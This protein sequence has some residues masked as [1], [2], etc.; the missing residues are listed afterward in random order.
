MPG[1]F[2]TLMERQTGLTAPSEGPADMRNWFM[3]MIAPKDMIGLLPYQ[4]RGDIELPAE[5][6]MDPKLMGPDVGGQLL[7]AFQNANKY[8]AGQGSALQRLQEA[9]KK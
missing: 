2:E 4:G 5:S 8:A 6:P 7:K 1:L 3:R 9:G